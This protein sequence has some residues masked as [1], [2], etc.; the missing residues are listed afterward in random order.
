MTNHI[1]TKD[2]QQAKFLYYFGHMDRSHLLRRDYTNRVQEL[3]SKV[4]KY[5]GDRDLW[6]ILADMTTSSS[7]RQAPN[8]HVLDLLA[9]FIIIAEDPG[10]DWLYD[11]SIIPL[12][13]TSGW[14]D[15]H[16]MTARYYLQKFVDGKFRADDI[17]ALMLRQSDTIPFLKVFYDISQIKDSLEQDIQV[18]EII[19]DVLGKLDQLIRDFCQPSQLETHNLRPTA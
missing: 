1:K 9:R 16:A 18:R 17:C 3:A 14:H 19:S 15:A 12:P 7:M 11:S 6:S 13:D 10:S 5:T 8:M 4:L 2:V